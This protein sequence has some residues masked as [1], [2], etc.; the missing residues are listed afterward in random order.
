MRS[1]RG[2]RYADVGVQHFFYGELAM[3]RAGASAAFLTTPLDVVRTR[4]VLWEGGAR[5]AL[6]ATVA[7]IYA[8][9]G[10]VGF[11]RGVLPRTVYMAMGGR[12]AG[13]YVYCG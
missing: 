9:E 6:S 1:L 5:Q 7:H 13:T 10:A 2:A 12:H 8:R 3:A 11:W 4:H